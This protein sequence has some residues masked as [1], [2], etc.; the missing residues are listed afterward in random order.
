[1]DGKNIALLALFCGVVALAI[2]AGILFNIN[3]RLLSEVSSWRGMYWNEV[4][5]ANR[6]RIRL[7]D[8]Y[9]ALNR[10]WDGEVLDESQDTPS[11]NPRNQSGPSPINE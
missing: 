1:M 10:T 6:I 3:T 9:R 7:G 2:L 5:A 11:A 8:A 4:A